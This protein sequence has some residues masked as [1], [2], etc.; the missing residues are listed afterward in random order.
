MSGRE[1][2]ISQSHTILLTKLSKIRKMEVWESIGVPYALISVLEQV[3]SDKPFKM[4]VLADF[5][6]LTYLQISWMQSEN[7]DS[8]KS[9]TTSSSVEELIN[10]H[11]N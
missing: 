6:L 1:L 9:I 5:M 10:S 3:S 11:P 7:V 2:S 8:T 4:L